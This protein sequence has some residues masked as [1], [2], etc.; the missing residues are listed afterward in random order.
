MRGKQFKMFAPSFWLSPGNDIAPV[1][2]FVK[3]G[4]GSLAASYEW[5]RATIKWVN[6]GTNEGM[7]YTH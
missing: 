3:T 2:K 4:T 5:Y 6:T 7:T 1:Q